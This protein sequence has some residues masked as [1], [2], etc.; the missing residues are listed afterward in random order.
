MKKCRSDELRPF[1]L[2][3][4]S[5]QKERKPSTTPGREL[6]VRWQGLLWIVRLRRILWGYAKVVAP[7]GNER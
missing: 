4:K 6:P 2:G 3:R 5:L 7:R 1:L